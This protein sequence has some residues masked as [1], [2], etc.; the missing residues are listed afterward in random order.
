MTRRV[1]DQNGYEMKATAQAAR[2]ESP[3]MSGFHNGVKSC[4]LI[5]RKL[6]TMF[7]VPRDSS[8]AI[9]ALLREIDRKIAR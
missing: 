4:S 8:D 6:G 3:S 9:D 2:L 1:F 5:G 7:E